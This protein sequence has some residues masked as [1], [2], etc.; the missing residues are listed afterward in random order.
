MGKTIPLAEIQILDL[1]MALT[2]KKQTQSTPKIHGF[3]PPHWLCN[4]EH[5]IP[6]PWRGGN[7]TKMPRSDPNH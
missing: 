5:E 1:F 2:W 7:N 6:Q 4:S 3:V